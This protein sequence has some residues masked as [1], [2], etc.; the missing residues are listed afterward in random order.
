MGLLGLWA[1]RHNT[2]VNSVLIFSKY[3]LLWSCMN[4]FIVVR[5][6]VW[7]RSSYVS[8]S[9]M[10][11]V[12]ANRLI[13]LIF[14]ISYLVI[15]VYHAGDA[16]MTTVDTYNLSRQVLSTPIQSFQ[17]N[18]SEDWRSYFS[19]NLLSACVTWDLKPEWLFL[20]SLPVSGQSYVFIVALMVL[21]LLTCKTFVL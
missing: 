10:I 16:Y 1:W 5:F 2:L 19:L 9:D 17:H 15:M 6:A 20:I 13:V 7:R 3:F 18:Q 8:S 21:K 11:I 4:L 12:R 14:V